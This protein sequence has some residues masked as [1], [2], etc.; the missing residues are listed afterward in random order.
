MKRYKQFLNENKK[1]FY[2]TIVIA[3]ILIGSIYALRGYYYHQGMDQISS[4]RELFGFIFTPFLIAMIRLLIVVFVGLF[5]A[6]IILAI[7]LRKVRMMQFEVEFAEKANEIANIQD[8]QLNQLLFLERVLK[9]NA[10]FIGNYFQEKE[11]PYREIIED[12]LESYE[13]FFTE[14]LKTNLYFEI[15][16]EKYGE[17]FDNNQLNRFKNTLSKPAKDNDLIR[18]HTMWNNNILMIHQEEELF[19]LLS[20]SEHEFTDYDIKIIKAL[21]ETTRMIC[22][23]ISILSE[24]RA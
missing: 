6:T 11:I 9:D 1:V 15:V 18:N 21:L 4:S 23:S 5:L 20:S 17:T 2:I 16:D 3:S 24:E 22:D 10:Y 14:E 19:I 12:I 8:K 7:P 13:K